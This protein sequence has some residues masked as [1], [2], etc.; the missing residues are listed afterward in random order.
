M[1]G[2]GNDFVVFSDRDNRYSWDDLSAL[3][4]RLCP[5]RFGI[6][7]DGLIAVGMS[8]LE[9]D[10]W[11]AVADYE[12]RYV[13]SDGS[14][15]E[16][17]G[18]GIRCLGKYAAEVLSDRRNILKVMT[19]AGILQLVL[20]R[21]AADVVLGATVGMGEPKLV[22]SSIPTTLTA[23]EA[24]VINVPLEVGGETLDVTCVNMGN[25]HAVV[26]VPEITDHHVLTLGKLMETHPAFP[27]RVNAEFVQVLDR[28]HERRPRLRM[29]VWERGCGETWACGTGACATMVAGV[30]SGRVAQ[31]DDVEVIV[32][33]GS[34]H[35][36]WPG[37]GSTVRLTGPAETVFK[38][39]I[40]I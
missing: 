35:I 40:E 26:F 32:N 23:P 39:E 15:A 37:P 2:C 38:G 33:G 7:A 22:A 18:N 1:H 24:R 21:N 27:E 28:V 4:R 14:R 36:E 12:M 11:P 31:C 16:M 17:C 20:D 19:G 5:Q 10:R 6:G 8:A 3:A 30:L 29:R 13:N 25:P 9:G 34:L